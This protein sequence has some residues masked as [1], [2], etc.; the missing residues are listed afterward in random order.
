MGE[1]NLSTKI[2][3]QAAPR[4]WKWRKDQG[5]WD[6]H[7]YWYGSCVDIRDWKSAPQRHGYSSP[8]VSIH[9]DDPVFVAGLFIRLH[10]LAD[11]HM[12]G[13]K[14]WFDHHGKLSFFHVAH[15]VSNHQE[16]GHGFDANYPVFFPTLLCHWAGWRGIDIVLDENDQTRLLC[17]QTEFDMRR[18][19]AIASILLMVSI[20]TPSKCTIDV[21]NAEPLA[22]G[23]YDGY[24]LIIISRGVATIIEDPYSHCYGI[25]WAVSKEHQYS[26]MKV[27]FTAR[28]TV[29]IRVR[30]EILDHCIRCVGRNTGMPRQGYK[31]I[32]CRRCVFWRPWRMVW[33]SQR[34]RWLRHHRGLNL[35]DIVQIARWAYF[36]AL[37]SNMRWIFPDTL[38]MVKHHSVYLTQN[39]ARQKWQTKLCLLVPTACSKPQTQ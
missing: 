10:K 26:I 9:L 18:T 24:R 32:G 15:I 21:L 1:A 5:G 38:W 16:S 30:D 37:W 31:Q 13:D 14:G 2:K 27:L 36:H 25:I 35:D 29:A 19:K 34:T 28:G 6:E 23:R 39:K 17:D 7:S 8:D 20:W 12:S 22:I 11:E 4:R 3:R 33:W